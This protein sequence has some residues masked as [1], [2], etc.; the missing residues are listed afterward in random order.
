MKNTIGERIKSL[1][2]S[3]GINQA[4]MGELIGVG[5][6]TVSGIERGENNPTIYQV[7]LISDYF[8]VTTDWII[9]GIDTSV[10]PVDRELI[11][12][13]HEDKGLYSS[14]MAIVDAKKS[15][16]SNRLEAA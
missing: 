9:K 15:L 4:E 6:K 11:N 5:Q 13:I 2:V 8:Q 7:T 14:I 16:L 3:R 1:R 12:S 10:A